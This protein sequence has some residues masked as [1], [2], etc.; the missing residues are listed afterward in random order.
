M[1][2][3]LSDN[4]AFVDDR[5]DPHLGPTLGT[6]QR[7]SLIHPI[8]QFRQRRA[9]GLVG[10][11]TDSC[12]GQELPRQ[13]RAMIHAAGAEHHTEALRAAEIETV[14][15]WLPPPPATILEIG[16]GNGHSALLLSERGYTVRSI[17][18]APWPY[19][20]RHPV[21][22]YDGR[23][24][25]ADDSS[26]DIVF[27][28]NVLEHIVD[29][30]LTMREVHRVLK[31]G[32]IAAHVVPTPAWRFWTTITYYPALLFIIPKTIDQIRA[33]RRIGA[34]APA[35]AAASPASTVRA[36]TPRRVLKWISTLAMSPRHGERGNRVT[37]AFYFRRA[38]WT[39]LFK[40]HRFEVN[41][42]PLGIAYTGNILFGSALP[43]KTRKQLALL[44][45]SSTRLFVLHRKA[46]W[47]KKG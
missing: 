18:V 2:Q 28:T 10:V 11:T 46:R 5:N 38:W 36:I 17:D 25:P 4:T 15:A 39:A 20:H 14:M 35:G 21:E 6:T 13:C 1:L 23:T 27:S 26:F 47:P 43:I 37:E 33:Q 12:A 22:I 44:L 40:R 8:D 41:D 34:T 7:V 30:S 9:D 29:L 42:V 19:V 31:P 16:G 24:L 32:G 45:G 3:Y